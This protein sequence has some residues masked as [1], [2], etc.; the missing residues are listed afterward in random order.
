MFYLFGSSIK[1]KDTIMLRIY[2][3]EVD[4]HLNRDWYSTDKQ[5]IE[6]EMSYSQF[7]ESITSLNQGEGTPVTLRRLD[8]KRMEDCPHVDKRIQFENEFSEHM[9]VINN[10][11]VQLTKDAEEILNEKKPPTKKDKE[12]I[13]EQIKNMQMEISSNIPFIYSSFN[14]QMD[15]TVQ[16][17]K[18]EIEGFMAHKIISAGLEALGGKHDLLQIEEQEEL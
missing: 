2:Q 16:E 6:V 5:Y 15:K 14:E 11:L 10:K 18:G 3:G 1:H 8:G 13:L 12:M 4:R 17:A 9:K 7:A